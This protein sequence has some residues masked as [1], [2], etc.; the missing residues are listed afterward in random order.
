MCRGETWLG[1]KREITRSSNIDFFW[2][3]SDVQKL[4]YFK[5][6]PSQSEIFQVVLYIPNNGGSLTIIILVLNYQS[7]QNSYNNV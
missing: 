7:I 2:L 4:S 1:F 3:V 5:I 6:T